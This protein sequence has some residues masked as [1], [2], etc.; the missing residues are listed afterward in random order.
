MKHTTINHA[1]GT[2]LVIETV[3]YILKHD[4]DL[5]KWR[6]GFEHLQQVVGE[7]HASVRQIRESLLVLGQAPSTRPENKCQHGSGSV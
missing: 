4:S 1:D 2:N 5:S 3:M 7:G 6:V